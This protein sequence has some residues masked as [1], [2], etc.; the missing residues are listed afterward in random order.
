MGSIVPPLQY[1]GTFTETHHQDSSRS[2]VLR[3][4][5]IVERRTDRFIFASTWVLATSRL[6]FWAISDIKSEDS[7]CLFLPPK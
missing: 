7:L 4:E 5:D 6:Q 2:Q 3:R 1:T